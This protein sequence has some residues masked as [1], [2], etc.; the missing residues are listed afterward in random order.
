MKFH[1]LTLFP[2]QFTSF[3]ETSI[4]GNA[5]DKKVISIDTVQIRDFSKDKHKKVD[6]YPFG[7]GAGMVMAVQPLRDALESIERKRNS[8]VI[9]MSPRG[10]TLNHEKVVELSKLDELVLVCGHYEGVDQRFI[11]NYVDE[12][13]SIGDY[14]LTGGELAAMVVVDSVSRMVD[15]VL[16]NHSSADEESFAMDL[17]EYP[18]YTRPAQIDGIKI[19]DVLLSGHHGEIAKWRLEQS[20]MVTKERRPDLFEKYKNKPHEKS[21]LKL[22]KK[23]L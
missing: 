5:V 19:P 9:Y 21:V 8:K 1:I 2:E 20:M 7:G 11:D 13:L 16:T 14:V 17:L 23:Y 10:T 22:L 18:H 12:E 15:S 3:M 6:D 4:I